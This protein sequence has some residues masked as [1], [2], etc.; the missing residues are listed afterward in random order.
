MKVYQ[1]PDDPWK[2][3]EE[4]PGSGPGG[5]PLYRHSS[6]KGVAGASDRHAYFDNDQWC[7]GSGGSP[8]PERWK[9][10][11]HAVVPPASTYCSNGQ[12]LI[13]VEDLSTIK[14]GQPNTFM[15]GEYTTLKTSNRGAFW[16]DS[17]ASFCLG[18]TF[19]ESRTLIPN[20]GSSATDPGTCW[21]TAG[22]GQENPCKRVFASLHTNGTN[23]VSVDDSVHFVSNFIDVNLYFALGTIA[24]KE[25]A[26]AP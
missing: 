21:G 15:V 3:L 5:P 9:G 16:A 14:D 17:Y 23:F 12:K 10:V 13:T 4:S 19:K 2:D 1:C 8:I 18:H 22:V 11:L 24:N 26:Q 25:V 7:G 20:F 6:Y